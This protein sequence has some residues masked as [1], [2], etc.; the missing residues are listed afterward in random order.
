MRG[1]RDV[2]NVDYGGHDVLSLYPADCKDKPPTSATAAGSDS[3]RRQLR[4]AA[5][6]GS[7]H[8]IQQLQPQAAEK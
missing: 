5:G 1:L 8:W 6:N 4:I 2:D 3:H 7:S